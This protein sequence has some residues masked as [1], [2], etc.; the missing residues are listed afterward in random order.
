[1]LEAGVRVAIDL[2]VWRIRSAGIVLI[3][4]AGIAALAGAA[5]P[6][7][8]ALAIAGLALAASSSFWIRRKAAES[9]QAIEQTLSLMSLPHTGD[10]AR[11]RIDIGG[12]LEVRLRRIG[13]SS[14]L[15]FVPRHQSGERER[16]LMRTLLKYQRSIR[17]LF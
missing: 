15:T 17:I 1:L 9:Y 8:A 13:R 14:L 6:V 10:T 12:C 3:V 5:W 2:A 4:A 11:L 16:Y 7:A